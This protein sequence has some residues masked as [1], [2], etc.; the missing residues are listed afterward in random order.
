FVTVRNDSLRQ[1]SPEAAPRC[2]N[3][4]SMERTC[5]DSERLAQIGNKYVVA[6]LI[7]RCLFALPHGYKTPAR[8]A[9]HRFL[10]FRH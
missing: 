1:D 5:A 3:S 10:R 4:V 6:R 2:G 9:E 7:A 8:A